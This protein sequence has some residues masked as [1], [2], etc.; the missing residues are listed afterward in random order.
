MKKSLVSRTRRFT[1]FQ[2]LCYALERWTRT[3][4]EKLFGKNNWVG[5]KIHHNTELWWALSTESRWNSTGIFPRSSSTIQEFM[6]QIGDMAQFQGRIIFVSMYNDIIWWNND[7]EQ[8]CIANATLVSLF[9]KK[10][11]QQD[12]DHSSDLD[13][14]KVVFYL[15]RKTTR[16]MGQSRRADDDQINAEKADTQ[17]SEPQV[18][19]LE[20]RL[21]AKEV[22]NYLFTSVPIGTKLRLYFEQLF[23]WMSSVSTEQSQMCEEYGSCQTRTGRPVLAGQ[24]DPLFEP[25]NLLLMTP[26]FSTEIP[27]QEN[28]VQKYKERMERL[29]QKDLLTEL[30]WCR[31]LESSWSRT[32][33]HDKAQW[34]VLTIYR[35]SDMSWVHFATR[36]KFNQN[37]TRVS[38]HNQ[39]LARKYGVE[40][41]I[42][43]VITDKSHSWSEFLMDWTSWSQTWST[44]RTTTTSRRP[45]RRRQKHLRWKRMYLLLQADQRLKQIQED[46]PPHAHLQELYL[47]VTEHGLILN[48]E[49]NPIKHT[50]WQHG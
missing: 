39:L 23:L 1:H 47:V 3:Q 33:L 2:I 20:E 13:Q 10:N 41:S 32:V 5:S 12:V 29:S 21:K 31:I 22:E 7:N 8:E 49:R 15:Q 16:R 4:H 11:F 14:K 44:K 34:R 30:Y 36:R 18:H 6:N 17:S 19:C 25:A 46:L 27:A 40:I 28:W 35:N 43:S 50:Q 37:W 24:S 42:E 26:R 48:Q 38:S 9:A 45:L